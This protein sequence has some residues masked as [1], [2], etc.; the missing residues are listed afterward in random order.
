MARDSRKF[1]PVGVTVTRWAF[2]RTHILDYGAPD[3][4]ERGYPLRKITPKWEP[5]MRCFLFDP[6]RRGLTMLFDTREQ[7]R[8]YARRNEQHGRPVRVTVSIYAE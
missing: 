4:S 6:A 5:H 1:G 8:E 3:N 2:L 7:A